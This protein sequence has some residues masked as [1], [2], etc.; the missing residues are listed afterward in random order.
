MEQKNDSAQGASLAHSLFQDL[1]RSD[2][3]HEARVLLNALKVQAPMFRAALHEHG[4]PDHDQ[5][6]KALCETLNTLV[7]R[8]L[9]YNGYAT[10][11][12]SLNW[13]RASL[14]ASLAPLVAHMWIAKREMDVDK[15]EMI[16]QRMAEHSDGSSLPSYLDRSDVL[17]IAVSRQAAIGS[18][19]ERICR[20]FEHFR[21]KTEVIASEVDRA[22]ERGFEQLQNVIPM[23]GRSDAKIATLALYREAGSMMAQIGA[24]HAEREFRA[25]EKRTDA[26]RRKFLVE[27]DGEVPFGPAVERFHQEM[28]RTV[29]SMKAVA[30][31]KVTRACWDSRHGDSLNQSDANAEHETAPK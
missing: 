29:A 1:Q 23:T 25:M 21:R 2:T 9:T 24:L 28:D 30:N 19:V 20:V 3:S 31:L 22:V 8:T 15:L 13:L 17:A 18:A 4:I 6:T 14:T 26:E 27:N 5:R 12:A 16:T 11:D 7:D 10:D